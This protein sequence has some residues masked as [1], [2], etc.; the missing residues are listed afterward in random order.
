MHHHG[1]KPTA[2][3]L[4]ANGRVGAAAVRAFAAAGWSVQ[5]QVRRAP[6][7]PLPPGATA[8]ALP[9]EDA[10][11]LATA[12]AGARAVVHA[13]NPPYTRW[14]ALTMPQLRQ[15]VAVAQRLDATF[16]LPGNVYNFGADMPPVLDERTPQR[17]ATRKGRVRVEL[18]GELRE[19]AA[20]GA[21]RSIVVRAGD[22]FGSGTGSWL[23][24][25]IVKQ[26]RRGK[27]VYPGPLDR[28]HEWA[29][30][31]DLAQAF[32]AAASRADALPAFADLPFAGC[33]P[34]GGELL[35][36]IERAAVALGAAPQGRRLARGTLPWPLFRLGAP[37]VPMLREIVEMSYLWHV[38]HTIDGSALRRAVGPLP[39]TPLD[40]ALRAALQ[41]LGFGAAPSSGPQPLPARH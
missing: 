33:S 40:A 13:V 5:A 36:A 23:D 35:D 29:Y 22:Y 34:T 12:A 2:L 25:V 14:P 21:L 18:E 17:A 30:L 15:G 8:L 39:A 24:L 38:P 19:L 32:V 28:P 27:L 37:V 16:M 1:H 11:G 26:L 31:P 4:G 41:A 3:V 10:A 7:A 6:T 9:L 20:R